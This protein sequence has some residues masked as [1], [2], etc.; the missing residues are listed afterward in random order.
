M[1]SLCEKTLSQD[2]KEA[3]GGVDRFQQHGNGGGRRHGGK[4]SYRD[5]SGAGAMKNN[6][7]RGQRDHGGSGN[8]AADQ[9]AKTISQRRNSAAV[10]ATAGHGV[11]KA[12]SAG[13]GMRKA[14]Y[15]RKKAWPCLYLASE[16][17]GE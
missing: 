9:A 2:L 5:G 8:G 3:L 14:A 17:H 4:G 6:L 10:L 7:W 16:A 11:L 13:L 12:L 1:A 15:E